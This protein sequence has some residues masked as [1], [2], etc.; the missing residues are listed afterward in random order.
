MPRP[1][2]VSLCSKSDLYPP[3]INEQPSGLMD[4]PALLS[5]PAGSVQRRRDANGRQR[6]LFDIS[7]GLGAGRVLYQGTR[8]WTTDR[9]AAMS[10]HDD[11]IVGIAGRSEETIAVRSQSDGGTEKPKPRAITLEVKSMPAKAM[12]WLITFA[13]FIGPGFMVAVAYIDPGNYATDIVAGATYEFKLLFVVLISNIFAILLQSLAIRLGTVTGLDLASMCRAHLP[14]WLNWFLYVM[15]EIAIMATDLVEVIGM[16]I[17]VKLL[18]PRLPLVAACALSF[19]DV[20]AILFFYRPDG[21]IRWLR[22]F[23]GFVSLLVLGVIACFGVQLSMM[24]NT[25]ATAVLHGYLPSAAI[26]ETDGL[27][28][29]CGILGATVMPHSLF[30]GS[31]LVQ[32]RLRDYD[33]KHGLMPRGHASG[34]LM[35]QEAY[36][37]IKY[38]PSQAAI[39]HSLKYSITE[40]ALSLFVFALFVNS[41]ILIVAGGSLYGKPAAVGKADIIGIHDLLSRSISPAVGTVFAM[42]LLM[43]GISAGIVC[44]MAGQM[45]SEG[46]LRWRLR[47]WLRRV[48]T[49]LISL[50]PALVIAGAVGREGLNAALMGS[51]VALSSVLPLV[52]LPLIVFTSR[53]RFMTVQPGKARFTGVEERSGRDEGKSIDMSNS[54]PLAVVAGLV[55]LTMAVMNVANLVLLGLGKTTA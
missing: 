30:L 42:A 31:G 9:Q 1:T 26:V 7:R 41:A 21:S 27:Y 28:Q 8:T 3:F 39:K 40:L 5:R 32:P 37:T 11:K 14:R 4:V 20:M 54:W 34:V 12:H 13:K 45:V 50:A 10:P 44:T 25:T 18:V 48:V 17:A 51:Q 55:W 29:S 2:T 33:T 19:L 36:Q 6:A 15:A 23:E 46:A 52:T 53:S 16:A 38:I 49:R 24:E 22:Y 47:P 43:S 35:T